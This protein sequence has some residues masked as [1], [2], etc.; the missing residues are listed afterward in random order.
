M[1]IPIETVVG[2]E[3]AQDAFGQIITT[4]QVPKWHW[5]LGKIDMQFY[6][7]F[8]LP[9]VVTAGYDRHRFHEWLMAHY[10]RAF[11]EAILENPEEPR[12]DLLLECYTYNPRFPEEVIQQC[13]YEANIGLGTLTEGWPT[14]A[15]DLMPQALDLDG[16]KSLWENLTAIRYVQ[17]S[18]PNESCP[19]HERK[20]LDEDRG[21]CP[22]CLGGV[23][24]VGCGQCGTRVD[25]KYMYDARQLPPFLYPITFVRCEDFDKLLVDMGDR[26]ELPGATQFEKDFG[27]FL[28][29][30]DLRI[31]LP[32][33]LKGKK[34]V[35]QDRVEAFLELLEN[36]FNKNELA[37]NSDVVEMTCEIVAEH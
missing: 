29:K 13:I 7:D 12:G 27:I 34:D 24:N 14:T 21:G 6:S 1:N 23:S 36:D 31:I 28:D 18:C 30:R 17:Y 15:E 25:V 3:P 32:E 19:S 35:P 8:K 4:D 22:K 11:S 26:G 2:P 16:C 33:A 10:Y 20:L 37:E 9:C 5:L